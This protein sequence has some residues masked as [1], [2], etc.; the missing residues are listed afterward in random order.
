LL[1]VILLLYLLNYVSNK[2]TDNKVRTH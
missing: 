1:P 2:N